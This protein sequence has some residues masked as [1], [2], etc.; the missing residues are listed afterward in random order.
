MRAAGSVPGVSSEQSNPGGPAVASG[1]VEPVVPG[2]V[3]ALGAMPGE[4]AREAARTVFGELGEPP[5]V[6]HLPQLPGRGPGADPVGRTA[7]LLVDLPV[8]LQPAGWRFVD[9]AGR[10]LHRARAFLRADLDE[11]AEAADGWTGSL[12]TTVVGP[13]SL[14]AAVELQRGERAVSDHGAR[15]DVIDSLAQGVAD[16][17]RDLRR[18]VPGARVLV[19]LEEPS[20]TAVLEGRLPTQ[21][22]YGSLRSVHAPEVRAG[23]TTVFDAVR[24]AGAEPVLRVS[25]EETPWSLVRETRPHA[26]AVDVTRLTATGWESVAVSVEAGTVLW[27]GVVPVVADPPPLTGLVE[28]VTKPWRRIGMPADLLTGIVVTPVDGLAALPPDAVR[29][30]LGR[31][32]EVG[33]AVA[34]SSGD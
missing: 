7:A 30:V 19:Q 21:S 2:V 20:L 22:G 25:A 34:E 33:A 32:R 9:A 24:A 6:P 29:G 3:T 31:L 26:V 16:H 1:P 18:L 17:V 14:V 10:D 4:D 5:H 23:L 28:A 27:A 11:L 15:R 12:G 8:D 13:W